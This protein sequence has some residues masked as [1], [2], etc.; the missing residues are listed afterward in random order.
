MDQ[1][2]SAPDAHSIPWDTFDQ[3][4]AG[5]GGV[6]ALSLLRSADRSRRLLLLLGLV[7]PA[8]TDDQLTG[9]LTGPSSAWDL[10]ERAER[11]DPEASERVL[12]HPYT[13]SWAGYV[14]RL[15]KRGLTGE[16][17]LWVHY[18]YLHTLA[19]AAAIHA[20][21]DFTIRVPVWNDTVVLP[22][23]GAAQL[24]EGGD[25][26]TAEVS[27]EAG[28]FTIRGERSQV[29]PGASGWSPLRTFRFE[30]GGR[31][32]E[33]RLDHLDPHRGLY[34]PVPPER[35]VEADLATWRNL[36][37]EAWRLIVE[38][39]PEYAE[40]LPSG[41]VSVVPE[42]A[43]PFR[44]PS[45][46]TGEA[47]GSM[48]VAAPE[49]PATLAA[50]LVHE[51]QHIRLGGLLQLARLHDDD[52]TE[53]LYAPWREDPR[54]LG[55]LVHGVYAFFGVSAFWRA[56]SRARPDDRLAAFEFA[57]WRAQTWQTLE[58]IRD[59]AALTDAG[60]RFLA[61]LATV[62]GPWQSE[63]S[64]AEALRR[65]ETLAAD[66]YAGW[67][68]RHIRPEP[69]TVA[70]LARAW[71]Q[72]A[73][74][75]PVVPNGRID[76]SSD[77]QWPNSRADLIRILLGEDGET[78]LS[79]LWSHVPHALEGDYYLVADRNDEARSA[80]QAELEKDPDDAPALIG[81]G[82][83]LSAGP[84]ARALLAVP[85]LVRAVHRK[86]RRDGVAPA[87]EELAGWIGEAVS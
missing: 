80:Y 9:P 69:E 17:P 58:A 74:C 63:P 26:T 1:V 78:R 64:T 36:L 83:S 50:A 42:P 48:V 25:F 12:A 19:A 32:L 24:D 37:G 15:I 34:H 87:A 14:T 84:A 49:D 85:E 16:C 35:L 6:A 60:R 28:S 29:T 33:L 57:H 82:L 4:A 22:T 43:V 62:F 61:E 76:T 20:G 2:A 70:V 68:L 41:L 38:H 5:G 67:R 55:G 45:A 46:S 40:V 66:H 81:L 3:L 51:F 79:R 27:G 44:L 65:A 59:D 75:P 72:K 71:L 8:T 54:P 10:L 7:D 77:G 56:L 21:L 47:F 86:L 23:L 13:G 30:T 52:R 31:A 53:R 73:P 39:V 11:A 18:G